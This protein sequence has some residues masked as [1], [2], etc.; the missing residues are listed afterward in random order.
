MLLVGV[1]MGSPLG[2]ALARNFVGL[3]EI[4]LRQQCKA[5]VYYRYVDNTFVMFGSKLDC[6]RFQEKRNWLHAT[7]KFTVG[8][9]QNNSLNFL[10]FLVE[11]EGTEFVTSIDRKNTFTGQYIHLTSLAQRIE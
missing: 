10:D 11:K 4:R 3:Y 7:P 5:G 9:E 1:A 8:M 2:L 6:N